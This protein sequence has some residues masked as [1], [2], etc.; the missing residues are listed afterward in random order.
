[1][2]ISYAVGICIESTQECKVYLVHAESPLEALKKTIVQ[3][4]EFINDVHAMKDMEGLVSTDDVKDFAYSG[5]VNL[6]EPARL[7][8]CMPNI[9][10]TEKVCRIEPHIGE[11]KPIPETID[12]DVLVKHRDALVTRVYHVR[13]MC[14]IVAA[15]TAISTYTV[16]HL[17]IGA[18]SEF[19][20]IE[21]DTELKSY[22]A[23]KHLEVTIV[24]R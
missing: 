8:D 9:P 5:G 11:G 14:P 20:S 4:G 24:Q 6:S 17:A 2:D 22:I 3:C 23:E 15:K 7:I 13:T 12:F 1:M 18:G 21:T 16:S 19:A 10:E